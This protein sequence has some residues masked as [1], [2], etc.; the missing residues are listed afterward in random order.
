MATLPSF[1]ELYR[2]LIASPSVSCLDAHWDTSNKIVI[3][4][5]AGWFELLGFT[6]QVNE[7]E[8][9]R[10]KFNMLASYY[11]DGVSS[12]GLLLSGHTDTVPWDEGRWSQDPFTLT[13]RDGRLYGLGSADMKGFFAFVLEVLR[14]LDLTKLS[15]PL[16]ILATADEETSMAGAREIDRFHGLK[17]DYAIIGEP[18]SMTPVIMHKGH[19][20]ESI[21]VTGKSGHSSNPAAGINAIEVMHDVITEL[22][23]I[24]T[25]FAER[26][27]D[28]HFAV[29]YPTLNLGSIH[30][31]DA[32]NRI[33][34]CCELHIDMRP[35]PGMQLN[36]MYELIDERL[37]E[38]KQKYPGAVALT[39]L[40][41]PIPGYR[42]AEDAELV[43]IATV[44]TGNAAEPANYCTE[45]PF[46]QAV[47][48]QTIILGPGSIAQA[49]QPDEYIEVKEIA[50]ALAQLSRLIHQLTAAPA[51]V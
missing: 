4:K 28:H 48:P 50:P 3:G 12:G 40:H 11:P 44:I 15:K 16:H 5:L 26:Y 36:E 38:V 37:A 2:E 17:P 18:T 45:A 51:P 27:C 34:A 42:C 46:I 23:Q 22:R 32:A 39:H 20:S 47:T 6:V 25:R 9:Q 43:D 8:A 35:L 24:Q 21:R 29:P 31:G 7:L 41:A 1:L 14:D 49:H 10:G 33:C 13:E 30:G 19:M